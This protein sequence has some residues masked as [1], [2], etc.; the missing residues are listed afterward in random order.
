MVNYILLEVPSKIGGI[1]L[2]QIVLIGSVVLVFYFFMIRPQQK[3]QKEQRDFLSHIKKGEKVV[4]IGGIHGTIYEVK[5]DLVTL[6][7]DNKGS[8]ISVSKG[9][10]SIESTKRYSQ[11]EKQ[12]TK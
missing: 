5:D 7:I 8:Q 9:A 4:T 6:V 2:Q 1:P 12:T 11:P 10:I 3:R